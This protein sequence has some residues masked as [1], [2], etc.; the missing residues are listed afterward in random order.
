MTETMMTLDE[1][2][3]AA[4]RALRATGAS[5]AQA[6][7]VAHSIRAAEAEG[8]RGI[9]LGYL[10]YYCGHLT[11]GKIVGDASPVAS[12]P[13]P[14]LIRVDA[15]SGFAH[16]AYIAGEEMLIAAAQSQ[17]IALMGIAN[18]YACG[19]LGYFT[20][21]LARRGLVAIM[22]ANASSTMAPFGGHAPFFGTNPW[23]FA[24]P[25][26]QEP[27]VIDS[28]SS[29]TAFVNIANAAAAGQAI[30]PT[31]ALDADGQ[32]TTDPAQALAGSIAP[33]GGHKGAALALMVE[34]LAAGLTG[35]NW[36]YQ[37]SSLGD[38]NGGPPN[39][40][41]TLIAIRADGLN[42][43]NP[44]VPR[45][46]SMLSAMTDQPGTRVPGDRRHANRRRAEANGVAVDAAL[47]ETLRSLKAIS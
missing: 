10:P 8:T 39:L 24:A 38:D 40:G 7:P 3:A 13:A 14:A 18:A 37:A 46:D 12:S 22:T 20:D 11:V 29:A 42:A 34:V 33:A 5:A 9:G 41:Q 43:G 28:S 4:F 32:P 19:V 21:R 2:E 36:S 47:L 45:L 27:L 44:L 15:A 17:G 31:W 25:R 23:S 26:A 35:A 16:P 6:A 1:V 30:P